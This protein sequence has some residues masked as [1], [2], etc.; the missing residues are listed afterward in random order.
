MLY[1]QRLHEMVTAVR[2]DG[3]VGLAYMKIFEIEQRIRQ[4]GREEGLLEG[5]MELLGDLGDIPSSL[6]EQI[7]AQKDEATLRAK[8]PLLIPNTAR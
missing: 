6:K 5:I 3:K 4:E 7:A 8:K 1:L 2:R